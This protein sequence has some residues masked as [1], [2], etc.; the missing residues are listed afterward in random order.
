MPVAGHHLGGRHGDETEPGRHLRLD[1][2]IDVRVGAHRTGELAHRDRRPRAT[3][4]LPVAQQL[5]APQGHLGPERRR[6]GMDTVRAS[7]HRVGTVP[8][9]EGGHNG[10]QVVDGRDD[11]VRRVAQRPAQTGVD[12]VGARQAV[13]QPGTGRHAHRLLQD[14]DERGHIVVRRALALLDTGHE[15]CVGDRCGGTAGRRRAGGNRTDPLHGLDDGHLDLDPSRHASLVGEESVGLGRGVTGDHRR[16]T[17]ASRAGPV[18]IIVTGTP[19]SRSTMS[20]SC[21]ADA[22]NPSHSVHPA[23]EVPQPG[24]VS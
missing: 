3:H 13:V 22:G 8:L 1:H 23:V 20:T 17:M 2:G 10:H 6:F 12:D 16:T 7:H 18:P 14:V 5:Q 24:R 4:P 11:E 19:V 15:S 21:R 9:G